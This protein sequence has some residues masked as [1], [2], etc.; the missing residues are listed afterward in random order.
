MTLTEKILAN[1][2]GGEAVA[3][4]QVRRKRWRETLG[5]LSLFPTTPPL[6]FYSLSSSP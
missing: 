5:R 4:G 1:H 2:S 6:T 3:P